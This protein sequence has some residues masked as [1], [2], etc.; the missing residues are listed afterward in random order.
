MKKIISVLLMGALCI[1]LMACGNTKEAGKDDNTSNIATSETTETANVE[2]QSE[3]SQS[4]ENSQTSEEPAVTE[5][6][7]SSDIETDTSEAEIETETESSTTL[8]VYF[9]AT[10]NTK[11]IA[12]DIAE[13]LQADI[14][15]IVPEEP[16]TDAD[17]DYNDDNSRSTLEMNDSSARPGISSTIDNFEQYTTIYLGYPIW[18]GEAP[19]I[20]DTFIESYDFTDKTV[21]PFCTSIGSGIGSSANTLASL[22][23]SGDWMN[24]Q[25]FGESEDADTVIEWA[26]QYQN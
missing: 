15:E 6:D 20:M 11:A 19:R 18:W 26:R 21:I 7:A 12:E 24:G 13:G 1:S 2:N 5:N 25:S 3:E 14:Y 22:A 4:A 8:V 16:Y 10:G 23:G 9:S 17:L